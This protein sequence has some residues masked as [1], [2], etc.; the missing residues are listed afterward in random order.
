MGKGSKIEK[1]MNAE[2]LPDFFRKM[3]SAIENGTSDDNAYLAAIEG[4]EKLKINIRTEQ[5]H[6]VIKIKAKPSK[7]V[8]EETP[9]A[10]GQETIEVSGMPKFS[11]LKKR[12]R[13][14][15][16][17]IFKTLHAGEM[18]PAEV[19]EEFIADSRLMTTYTGK[20]YGDEYF[21]EYLAAC[22]RFQSAFES[23]SIE[24]A[25]AACDE[26]NHIKTNCHA[27]YD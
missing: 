22:D 9:A 11:Q 18:P 8:V 12:M 14:S 19:V 25:H 3:A 7:D 26:L 6:T 4:F 21:A 1:I 16:K 23:G 17:I 24:Q 27:K 5:G 10:E 15:F 20:G 2:E 13:A